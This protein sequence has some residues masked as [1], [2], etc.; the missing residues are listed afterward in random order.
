MVLSNSANIIKRKK[1]YIVNGVSYIHASP[2]DGVPRVAI[3]IVAASLHDFFEI[4]F[5]TTRTPSNLRILMAM[6]FGPSGKF[7]YPK[8]WS[9][10]YVSLDN[11]GMWNLRSATWEWLYLRQ[12]FYLRVY[13][14][15]K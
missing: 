8:S 7:V 12:Q 14:P 9:V 11:Q 4:V 5:Q 10:I 15:V 1:R 6:I 2:N 3:V 13:D